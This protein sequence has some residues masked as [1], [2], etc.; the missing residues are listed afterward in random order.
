MSKVGVNSFAPKNGSLLWKLDWEEER[1][2]Q[3]AINTDG[4]LL[5]SAGGIRGLQRISIAHEANNWKVN[6]HWTTTDLKPNFNDI[7][8]HKNYVFG[9]NGPIL[10]CV[11]VETGKRVWKGGR[12]GG[13]LLL[14]AD[15]DL[16][17]I[18]S[19]KGELALVKTDSEQYTELARFSAIKGKTWN[20]PVLVD[21]VLLVRNAVEMAAFQL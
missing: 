18:L 9:F 19:E 6:E 11:D 13:Q 10:T 14:L 15:Q 4:D 17:L 20:H 12:Y 16:L 3:P 21:N 8:I 7:V 5:I 1:I 2:V